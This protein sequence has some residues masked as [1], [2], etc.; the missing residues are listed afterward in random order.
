MQCRG[1]GPH[2]AARGKSHC[3]SRVAPGTLGTFLSYGGEDPSK[4]V[5]VQRRQDTCLVMRDTSGNSSRLGRAIRPHLKLRRETQCPFLFATVI[6]VFL[7][8]FNKSQASSL[9]KAL[10]T[11]CL[12][13]CLWDVRPPLQMSRVLGHSLRSPQENK[14]FLHLLR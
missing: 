9:F 10:N 5:F 4:L 7:S 2:I 12:S 14:S 11:A 8:N 1:I 13:R 6:L 3:F